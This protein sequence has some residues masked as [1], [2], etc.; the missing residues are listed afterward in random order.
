MRQCLAGASD[1]EARGYLAVALGLVG[2][3]GSAPRLRELVASSRFQPELLRQGALAL[4]LLGDKE[5]VPLLLEMLARATSLSSQAALASA[6]GLIGDA[7]SLDGLIAMTHAG[8][9]RTDL[10]R[11]FA[12]VALGMCADKEQLPWNARLAND[13]NFRAVTSTLHAP[14]SGTG[15][16][17][18]L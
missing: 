17:D 12:A 13:A 6:L 1:A 3:R 7:R 9:Q 2:D 4:G 16:L 8:G 11:A 15:I 10:A 14:D 18:I 5:V